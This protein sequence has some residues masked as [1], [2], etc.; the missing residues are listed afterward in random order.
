MQFSHDVQNR[1][2]AKFEICLLGRITIIRFKWERTFTSIHVVI[3]L[4]MGPE[5]PDIVVLWLAETS[6][7]GVEL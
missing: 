4:W 6:T 7:V 1:A 3:P 5:F 2:K